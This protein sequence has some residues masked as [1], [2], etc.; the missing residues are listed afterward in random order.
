MERCKVPEFKQQR[1]A[2]QV[3]F[4]YSTVTLPPGTPPRQRRRFLDSVTGSPPRLCLP[5]RLLSVHS[6]RLL[7]LSHPAMPP[8]TRLRLRRLAATSSSDESE[9]S[10]AA[11]DASPQPPPV[12]RGG[13]KRRRSVATSAVQ[14]AS[15]DSERQWVCP[16]CT[17][18]NEQQATQCKLCG[19]ARTAAHKTHRRREHSTEAEQRRKEEEGEARSERLPLST[20]PLP[21]LVRRP[22][23]DSLE[24]AGQYGDSA[25]SESDTAAH[26]GSSEWC[27]AY[28]PDSLSDLAV[29]S[30]KVAD[31]RRWLQHNTAPAAA[32]TRLPQ[33]SVLLLSGPPGCGKCFARGT[34]LRLLDGR[35]VAVEDV[36]GGEQ[37]M[38][39]DGLPRTVTKGSLTRGCGALY[40]ITPAWSG[41]TPFT[42]NGAHILVLVNQQRPQ[43]RQVG[44]GLW[45]ATAWRL[46]ADNRMHL[47]P[48]SAP[49]TRSQ[50][51]TSA[52]A[53]VAA[54]WAP[55][56]WEVSVNSF[57]DHSAAVRRCCQLTASAA[58]SFVNPRLPSLAHT[59]ALLLGVSPSVEQLH[60]MAW[61]LGVWLPGAVSDRAAVSLCMADS[62]CLPLRRR[63]Q[64]LIAR[65]R[66]EYERLFAE[67]VELALHCSPTAARSEWRVDYGAGTVA[68]RVLHAYGLL[69]HKRVPRPL[70]G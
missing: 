12:E 39:D 70:L 27:T 14:S 67:R 17:L 62:P 61:W 30:R 37:L 31:V 13:K 56:E 26:G 16:A 69:G 18:S 2:V 29:H 53:I 9:S 34:R 66:L 8:R 60:C 47:E 52:A 23:V 63:R 6:C 7:L 54:G 20:P 59:L 21:P 10:E 22:L 51:E 48:L 32:S 68:S 38:G 4:V 28:R 40:R 25:E 50:A 58:I 15:D 46:T 49:D 41:A 3:L 36:R 43:A 33:Q 5:R 1:F 55:I 44:A 64:R 11:S 65:L 19:H 45:Q 35:T 57:L 24:S 42:V